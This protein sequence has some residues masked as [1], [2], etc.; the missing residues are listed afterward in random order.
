[1]GKNIKGK[2]ADFFDESYFL[3][4]GITSTEIFKNQYIIKGKCTE[5]SVRNHTFLHNY[6]LL[7][8]RSCGYR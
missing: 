3:S 8:T 7:S 5:K 6:I 2:T 4:V 1:M